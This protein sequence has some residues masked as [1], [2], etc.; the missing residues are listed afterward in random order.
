MPPSRRGLALSSPSRPLPS[1]SDSPSAPNVPCASLRPHAP[2]SPPAVNAQPPHPPPPPPT[3]GAF[4]VGLC[5]AHAAAEREHGHDM[6]RALAHV[7][8]LHAPAG[9]GS[10]RTNHRRGTKNYATHGA[11]YTGE[12]ANRFSKPEPI[13]VVR[14]LKLHVDLAQERYRSVQMSMR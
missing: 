7:R 1:P 3:C 8:G 4:V 5:L 2:S 13:L 9:E 10:Q 6:G 12:P 11:T 14:C